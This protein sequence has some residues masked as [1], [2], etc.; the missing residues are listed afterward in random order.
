MSGWCRTVSIV[1]ETD[2]VA[3]AR[4]TLI[5]AGAPLNV[6]EAPDLLTPGQASS[7]VLQTSDPDGWAFVILQASLRSDEE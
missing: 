7:P 2:D 1:L 4:D 5:A 6:R 3:A